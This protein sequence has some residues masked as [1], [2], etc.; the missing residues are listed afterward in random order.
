MAMTEAVE[1]AMTMAADEELLP[2]SVAANKAEAQSQPS[3]SEE[4][5]AIAEDAFKA[6]LRLASAIT[7]YHKV[8][9]VRL[10]TPPP[11]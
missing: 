7:E 1:D 5:W 3:P 8:V 11:I 4:L 6:N 2:A 10:V 9:L